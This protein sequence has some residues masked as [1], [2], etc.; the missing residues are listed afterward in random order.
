MN[1]RTLLSLSLCLTFFAGNEMVAAPAVSDL[2]AVAR[3]G[4]IFLTWQEAETPEH[5]TFNV[6]VDNS[7]IVN[8]AGLPPIAHHIEQHSARDWW[9]DPASFTKGAA[10]GKPVGWR[11]VPGGARL[12]P[13]GGLFVYRVFSK[14]PR[15]LFF[16]VT[17]SDAAGHEDK[18]LTPRANTL[19][20]GVDWVDGEPQPIWQRDEAPPAVGAGKGKP[21]WLN[22]HAKSGV[23]ANSEYLFFGDETMGWRPGLP[24][25]FSVR[26]END[27][28]VVRPTDRVWINRPHDEARDG[29]MPAIWTFWYG[30]NSHI[31]DRGLMST[32]VPTNYTE[33]RNL[34]IL[35][36]LQKQYQPDPN[37]WSCSGS[38]M[39]GCGTISFG[40]HHPELFAACHAHVPI[41]AYTDLGAK[42]EARLEPC[43][44][45][46][47]IPGD[48]KTNEDQTL[49]GRM[50]STQFVEKTTEDLPYLFILN[51]RQD[52]SIP[53]QNNPPFYKALAAAHQGFAVYWDNG[54]HA[55]SGKDAPEDVKAWLQRIRRFRRDESYPAFSNTSTDR[56]PGNG[57][58]DD[59]DTIGWI[60]RGMDWKEIEDTYR[61][62]AITLLAEPPDGTYPVQTDMT[63]R[64]V[65]QFK[66]HPGE[67]VRV[68]IG[69]AEPVS[70]SADAQ[71]RITVPK[72][73]IPD[74]AGVRVVIEKEVLPRGR[75]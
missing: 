66:T 51:G 17:S 64:R 32:G 30:Y 4:Q 25:K 26:L 37:H 50:N 45:T 44:W 61:R 13:R 63:L 58:P 10:A 59:G 72:V 36:W 6:Y 19:P 29:G 70:V 2:K 11:I 23:I 18:T 73:A 24:F 40:L 75:F 42:S 47:P 7:P 57:A 1:T 53:W 27:T 20:V 56:N 8:L 38:S 52:G 62:Y 34:W 9:E 16:A 21:L 3:D 69:N 67:K 49:L 5:T 74:K 71:G 31:Y 39:G 15:T 35:D 48:L 55:T 14:V 54:T 65:Q 33:R 28:V 46:G 22:L 41:V 60:N 43:C 68:R 12:D